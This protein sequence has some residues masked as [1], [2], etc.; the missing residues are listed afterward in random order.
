MGKRALIV[1]LSLGGGHGKA[2]EVVAAALR[3]QAG[4]WEVRC[5]DLRD[6]MAPWLRLAY[7]SGYLFIIRHVPWIYG[8]LYRHPPGR[9]GGT[10]PRWM[11]RLG[12]RRFEQLVRDVAPDVILATQLTASEAVNALRARG[13]YGGAAA[14]AITD[15]DAHP[16]WRAD[17]IDRFFVPDGDIAERLGGV[18]IPPE[19][20]EATG[21]PIDPVFEQEFDAAAL[22]AKHG[23]R[24]GV[25]VVLLMGGSL[26]LGSVEAAV[27][28]LLA[29]GGPLD[30]LVVAGHNERLR[31]RLRA[32]EPS[33]QSRLH[34]FGFIDFVHELMAVA[35]AFVSKPGG[36]SMTEAMAIGVPTL[37]VAPLAGQEQA[38]AAHLEAQGLVRCLQPGESLA[39][40]VASLLAD[41]RGPAGARRRSAHRVASR[42]IELAEGAGS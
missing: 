33:G 37:V 35:D 19:R 29:R 21:V 18:G 25:P 30:V 9:K 6:Y 1:S 4:D 26:G 17:H 28:E 34:V 20:I 42:L 7:V 41:G 12:T 40:A 14:T 27:R 13:V 8:F 23:V 2:G 16:T 22:K 31:D 24:P 36:L 5:I 11:L 15:F 10:L 32:V 38:N 39:D 3:E